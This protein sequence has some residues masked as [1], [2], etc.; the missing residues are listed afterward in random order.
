MGRHFM[1]GSSTLLP[2]RLSALPTRP[3]RAIALL[4]VVLMASWLEGLWTWLLATAIA[5]VDGQTAPS[6]AFLGLV[7]FLAWL[8]SR[9]LSVVSSSPFADPTGRSTLS[10]T[11]QSVAFPAA[12]PARPPRLSAARRRTMLVVGGLLVAVGAG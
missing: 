7:I 1:R 11:P 3:D 9:A 2:L 4:T 10:G 6:L 12:G 5:E 8:S